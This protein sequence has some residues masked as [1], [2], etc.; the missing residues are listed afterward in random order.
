MSLLNLGQK[1]FVAMNALANAGDAAQSTAQKLS[2]MSPQDW[3]KSDAYQDLRSAGLSHRDA[4]NMLAPLMAVPSQLV[5]GGAGAVSGATGLEK[6]LAGNA[7]T[8]GAR[9][10]AAR[11]AAEFA[12]EELEALAP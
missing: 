11:A 4:V 1:S 9:Q 12:G 7:I 10:R 5:G 6:R 8:G 2:Q 3:S